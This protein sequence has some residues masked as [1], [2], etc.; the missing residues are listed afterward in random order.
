MVAGGPYHY[1]RHPIYTAMNNLRG[2]SLASNTILAI[3]PILCFLWTVTPRIGEEE[4]ML[5][6]T[7]GERY[8]GSMQSTPRF[9]PNF[10]H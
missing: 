1:V 9:F 7:F 5:I 10:N 3:I 8:R 4:R 2:G 6:D